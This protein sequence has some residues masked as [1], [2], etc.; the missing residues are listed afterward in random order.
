[1]RTI[2]TTACGLAVLL[3]LSGAG[4]PLRARQ[5]PPAT[6]AAPVASPEWVLG[7]LLAASDVVNLITHLPAE[8]VE[9]LNKQYDA[10]R[11]E[12]ERSTRDLPPPP[13]TGEKFLVVLHHLGIGGT[14][15]AMSTD[16]PEVCPG[17]VVGTDYLVGIVERRVA[18]T[19]DSD[20]VEYFGVLS[21]ATKEGLCFAKETATGSDYCSALLTGSGHAAVTIVLPGNGDRDD[22][23][24]MIRPGV[25][26][27]ATPQPSGVTSI[28][29]QQ[30]QDESLKDATAKASS[31]CGPD[32]S[33]P[34][35]VEDYL[36]GEMLQFDLPSEPQGEDL[37]PL[38]PPS[39]K[40]RVTP[41]D[42]HL[43]LVDGH[44]YTQGLDDKPWAE[45]HHYTMYVA[46]KGST[47]TL[48]ANKGP[49]K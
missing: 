26:R 31:N 21:R 35:I 32:V 24:V 4:Q 23:K 47:W 22:M 29:F 13:R 15:P 2:V 49:R 45:G 1:M 7:K 18:P 11:K 5:A 40:A 37:A 27:P 19:I 33:P 17:V 9:A 3:L 14:V 42:L 44:L 38:T 10:G 43:G 28:D 30:V 8:N 20:S 6:S 46:Q 16:Q 25:K 41:R 36:R 34:Q 12:Y 39:S 48:Q